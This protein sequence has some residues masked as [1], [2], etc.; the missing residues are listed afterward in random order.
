M[1]KEKVLL[2]M[3]GG[4]DS[5]MSAWYLQNMGYEV[6]GI[7]FNTISNSL[8][9]HTPQF[10]AEAQTL[11]AQLNI[12]HHVLDVYNQ[13]KKEVIDYFVDEYLKGRTPNPCIRCNETIKWKLLLEESQRLQCTKISTGHYVNITEKE[14]FYHIQKGKDPS[15]D[16]SYFL[17]N[18]PQSILSRCIFP[19]GSFLKSE[20]KD[21]AAKL[22]FQSI[23]KKRE[24]MGVCFLQGQDYRSYINDMRPE[25][26]N[27]LKN[28][29]VWNSTGNK[30]GTHDG[31]P[32][33]T[34]GQKRG[35][36]LQA[37][38]GEYVAKIDAA[39]NRLI[40][41]P[42]NTLFTKH[43]MIHTYLTSNPSFL[44]GP[45][46]VD[47]RIR[48]LDAVPPTPG[49]IE[50]IDKELHIHFSNPVWALTPGQSIVFY[51]D[52][53]VVGGGIVDNME[54]NAGNESL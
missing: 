53:I 3:S 54:F 10:I 44:Q 41:A 8:T 36:N 24:S 13:F 32:Y 17:W 43:L 5:S 31:F 42:K 29:E 35:I 22:G 46:Q 33:Y 16:Q 37:D 51:Q 49:T 48:G 30:I 18:L 23:V 27:K 52:N 20:V 7:T 1:K 25:L 26:K 45:Q 11:A 21:K 14:G 50:L 4:I 34:I 6:I 47:L 15:K 28:G 2:G 40:T 19:L 39:N 9:D 38:H 12:E